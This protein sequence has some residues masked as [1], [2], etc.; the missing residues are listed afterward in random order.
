M[1]TTIEKDYAW[2]NGRVAIVHAM[3]SP[4]QMTDTQAQDYEEV[5]MMAG[6]VFDDPDVW[7]ENPHGL[8]GGKKPRELIQSEKKQVV[9]D[10]L[11]AIKHGMFT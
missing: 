10:L 7:L 2:T 9:I 1:A 11:G 3:G 6:E 5:R 4:L 8:L